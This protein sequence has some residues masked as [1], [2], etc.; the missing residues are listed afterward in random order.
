MQKD[1]LTF[2]HVFVWLGVG[3]IQAIKWRCCIIVHGVCK[4]KNQYQT[5]K[6][7]IF[8]TMFT[9]ATSYFPSDRRLESQRG[10]VMMVNVHVAQGEIFLC[11]RPVPKATAYAA[12]GVRLGV[13]QSRS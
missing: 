6:K 8:L 7:Q 10:R 12:T 5:S 11:E 3:L 13:P 2:L 4:K 9:K 1:T